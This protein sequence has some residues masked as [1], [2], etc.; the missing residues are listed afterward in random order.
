[1]PNVGNDIRILIETT[2]AEGAETRKWAKIAA[3]ASI[4]GV[5]VSALVGVAAVIL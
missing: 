1:M 4:A 3:Y 2:K 5:V